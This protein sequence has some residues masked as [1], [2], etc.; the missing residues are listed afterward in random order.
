MGSQTRLSIG[1]TYNGGTDEGHR[2]WAVG[3]GF[4]YVTHIMEELMKVTECGQSDKAFY[5]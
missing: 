1:N 3:Q 5:T 4:L 2:V